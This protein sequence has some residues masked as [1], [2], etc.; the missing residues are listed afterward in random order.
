MTMNAPFPPNPLQVANMAQRMAGNAEGM[1]S[2]VF[3]K[4]AMVSMG[5]MAVASVVQVLA[6][7]LRELNRKHDDERS[8]GRGR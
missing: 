3:Q 1:D 2:R 8:R 5:V 4:V 7:L 6:P